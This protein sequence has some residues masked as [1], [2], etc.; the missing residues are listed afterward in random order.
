VTAPLPGEL[1]AGGLDR[2]SNVQE[3]GMLRSLKITG[4]NQAP[5]LARLRPL[6]LFQNF[7]IA[8]KHPY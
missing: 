7:L 3:V 1:Q 2:N 4:W 5:T 8:S 6:I